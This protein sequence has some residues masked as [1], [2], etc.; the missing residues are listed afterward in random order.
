M[1][2]QVSETVDL[3]T[4]TIDDKQVR[5]PKG[6]NL[7]EA[8]K[9]VG[10]EIPHYCYHPHLSVPGNCRMCQVKVEGAPKLMIGCHSIAQNDMVVRTHN[11]SKEVDDAQAATLE[12]ILIN[13]PLDCTVCDQAGHCKLQDYHYEYN[14]RPSRFIEDKVHKPKAK[15]LG[16]TVML[17]AERCIMCT[18]C[19]RFCDEVTGTSE[20]G[21]LNRGDRSEI[22]VN[23]NQELDNP[24]SGS[25]VDLCP[26][27][28]LTHKQWRFNTRIWFTDQA[29]SICPGCSTGCNVKVAERDGQIVQVKAR[30]NDAVN[31]EWMCDEGRYGFM[32]FLPETRV[33]GARVKAESVKYEAAIKEAA[34]LKAKDTLVFIASDLLC[35]DYATIK[36]FVDKVLGN[37]E[38]VMAY[39]SRKL[40]EVEQVLISPDYAPNFKGAE[41]LGLVSGDLEMAYDAALAKVA[42]NQAVNLLIIGDRGLLAEDATGSVIAGLKQAAC[43]VGIFTDQNHP[44]ASV[45]SVL[46]G[47]RSILEKSGLMI[48]R[49]GRLQYSAAAIEVKPGTDPEW[50]VLKDVAK[51]AGVEIGSALKDRE[52]T[53][54]LLAAETKFSGL[55]IKDIKGV[56][57]AL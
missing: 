37:A 22:T 2:S 35:E 54:E 5:V 7:I 49:T 45:V 9:T 13:H 20:L 21:M 17:D 4:L 44:A 56:G 51:S 52:R 38:V 16:P 29:D 12:F 8:A 28:A 32:R 39:R 10:I 40:S 26:V 18:R 15:S 14:A 47:G 25:V 48:N 50:R 11:T 24:L 33:L 36:T 1:T 27:G 3:V 23:P 55:K 34:G 57:I 30:L 43:S 31:K 53:L 46:L 42:A 6:T 41:T 19:I